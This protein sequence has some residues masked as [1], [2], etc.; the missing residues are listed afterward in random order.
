MAQHSQALE[1]KLA[2]TGTAI[3]DEL[4]REY[5]PRDFAVEL[6]NGMRWDPDPGQFCR[7]T[8][9]IRHPALFRALLRPNLQ[10]ALA[11][12]FI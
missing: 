5:H 1:S 11:E 8:W 9:H 3:V 7:F 2:S 6:W 4:V 10:V 12:A